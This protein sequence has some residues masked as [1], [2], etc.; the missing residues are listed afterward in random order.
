MH[1][2]TTGPIPLVLL[3]YSCSVFRVFCAKFQPAVGFIMITATDKSVHAR[4]QCRRKM[5][6]WGG[7]GGGVGGETAA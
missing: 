4:A 1:Q 5:R 3:Y 2:I 6:R 7:V